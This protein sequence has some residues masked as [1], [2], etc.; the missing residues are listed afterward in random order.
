MRLAWCGSALAVLALSSSRAAAQGCH[1]VPEGPV[2]QA[3]FGLALRGESARFRTERYEGHHEGLFTSVR[4]AASAWS[5]AATLPVYRLVRNGLAAGGAGDVALGGRARV[6]SNA[7][8]DHAAG[9]TVVVTLPT[10]D[11]D[12]E[13]GM[14][15]PMTSVG[16][17]GRTSPVSALELRAELVYA[18]ALVSPSG[19]AHHAHDGGTSPLVDPMN[20]SE[21][22][23]LVTASAFLDDFALRAGAYAGV[24]VGSTGTAR[25]LGLLG[26]QATRGRFGSRVEAH[27]PLVGRPFTSKLVVELSLAL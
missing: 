20:A 5:A 16:L 18:R 7:T 27:A 4:F 25:L 6:L 14:G 23:P 19:G 12:E 8:D 21:L 9:A 13:L 11:A 24:P 22:A 26:I 10:G 1:A 3:G 17:W 2:T 15:H